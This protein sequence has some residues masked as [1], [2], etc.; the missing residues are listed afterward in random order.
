MDTMVKFVS[1]LFHSTQ[2]KGVPPKMI[3]KWRFFWHLLVRRIV[4]LEND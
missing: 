4:D 1:V 3:A 2:A